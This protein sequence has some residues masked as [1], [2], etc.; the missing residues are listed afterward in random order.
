MTEK[1][2]KHELHSHI[3][4][5]SGMYIGSVEKEQT[6]TYI[7]KE[8]SEIFEKKNIQYVPGFYKIVD[9]ILVN[10]SDQAT[11][12]LNGKETDIKQ[13]KNIKININKETGE[14]SVYNDGD[15]I[16]I[17]EHTEYN[18][19]YI[20]SLIFGELLTSTNY[21][22]EEEKI[23]GGINGLGAK[24]T[25][26]FST[27]FTIETVDFRRSKL[28]KQTFTE[29]MYKK[30]K[31]SI[32]SSNKQPYTKITFL[33]DYKRFGLTE[34]SEDMFELFHKRC[35]DLCAVTNGNVSVFFNDVKINIK[36]FEKYCDMYL[37]LKTIQPRVYEK[38][39]E[40]WEIIAS[41]SEIG[42]QQVSFVNG[43]CVFNG[44]TNIQYITNQITK[45][46][47]D[48][49]AKKKKIIKPN[50]IKEHL[51]IFVK[52]SIINPSFNSQSKE[53]LTTPVSKFGSKC[54]ISDSFMTKLYKTGIIEKASALTEFH[55]IKKLVKTDGKKSTRVIIEKLDDAIKAGTK[56]SHLCTLILTEGDSARTTAVS[57]LSVVGREYYGVFPLK[58]KVMNVKDVSMAKLNENTEITNLKKIIGLEH[59]KKYKDIT[60]LR[61]GKIMIMCDADEDGK[62]IQALLFNLFHSQ[63]HDLFE[64]DNFL[65][66]L[67]TPIIKV[68]NSNGTIISFYTE[69]DY[70]NWEKTDDSKK[71]GW[72][73]KY[74]K[75]LGTSSDS[76]AKEYFRNMKKITYK[77]NE[78]S[79]TAMEL[80][81]NKK[82][83]DER[84]EWLMKYDRSII[85]NIEEKEVF[86]DDFINKSLIHF[87]NR[88]LERSIPSIC[89]G[90]KESMRKILFACFKKKLTKEIK[91]AQLAGYVSEH[92]VYK[93]GENSLQG[94]IIGLAQN[95]IGTNNLN[96]LEP[97]GQ[98]GCLSGETEILM[99]DSSLKIAENI[100]IGDQ[101]IG[102]NGEKRVVKKLTTGIDNMYSINIENGKSFIGNSQHMLTLLYTDHKKVHYNIITNSVSI[103]FYNNYT[104]L[105][106]TE[107][108]YLDLIINTVDKGFKQLFENFKHINDNNIFDIKI[109]DFIKIPFIYKQNFYCIQNYN[110]INWNINLSISINPYI[111]GF[112]I[113]NKSLYNLDI[114]DKNVLD[115]FI[116][117]L[118]IINCKLEAYGPEQKEVSKFS[119]HII[120]KYSK[121]SH[122]WE[123]L[124]K[125]NDL[126]MKN[127]PNNYIFTDKKNRLELL[128]G[129]IDSSGYIIYEN[130][131]PI[132]VIQNSKEYHKSLQILIQSLGFITTIDK[133]EILYIYGNNLY[134][135]PCKIYTNIIYNYNPRYNIYN[136]S[137]TITP[138]GNY[139]FYGWE[140]DQNNRFLLGN[141]IITH[142]SRIQGG[143]DA[144]SPRYIYTLLTKLCKIVYNEEDSP[145]LEYKIDEGFSIEPLYY[146]PIIPM[147]LVNGTQ[148]IGTG[149]ST[150][151]PNY[152]PLDIINECKLVC[153]EIK[154][155]NIENAD[156]LL[157]I[158]NIINKIKFGKLYPWYLGNKG[159]IIKK[160]NENSYISKGVYNIVDDLHIEITELP[161]YFWTED[162]KEF[163]E[164]M[165]IKN[166]IK[167]FESHYTT[168]NVKF[169]IKLNIGY[170]KSKIETDFK[171]ISSKNLSCNNFHL[172]SENGTIT[173]YNTTSDILREWISV[174]IT[175]YLDRKLYKI[176]IL[177]KE[178]K[179]ISAK[180]R[181]ITDVISYKIKI[182][183]IPITDIIDILITLK[184]PKLMDDIDIEEDNKNTSYNYLLKL[185]ISQ[186]TKER[187]EKLEKEAEKKKIE[188]E[189][190][191]KKPIYK[192]WEDEL[193]LLEMEYTKFMD[194]IN[195]DYKDDLNNTPKTKSSLK[196]KK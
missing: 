60:S 55:D 98:F 34:L 11:R 129:I 191:R 49:A 15:G 42:F 158:F 97:N 170:D 85:L 14:I 146:I 166:K 108:L 192:M 33:P 27:K 151:I 115:Y 48:M 70:H 95:F 178:F 102:D 100:Q 41:I 78:Y 72:T 35:Y 43:I 3:L 172:Y 185:P 39:N 176:K 40:R 96:I 69:T 175:K 169:L 81:F 54:D 91:V 119:F 86:Y 77:Y 132:I 109:C 165:L 64:M 20:P 92:T 61:Y 26:I 23:I 160:E 10:A 193:L 65:T 163:L 58:G 7:Y 80:A 50:H 22:K 2:K 140:I 66:S 145:I 51:S 161:V 117:Y 181:F 110:C 113:A 44:G 173:K 177:E 53:N 31:P 182:M 8:G 144:S 194:E 126:F 135:I 57:G 83:A 105:I 17:I 150:T 93:H 184:Y 30:G 124:L 168:K 164:D 127:I 67:M 112:I 180:C 159:E 63:W 143:S 111:T 183:N 59:N 174:R 13:V 4:E 47:V 103:I 137:F 82:K 38:A 138:F 99:W 1:Y 123:N 107:Y 162:Y 188:I 130:E 121:F 152:N 187:K 74:F 186:L 131:N 154:E 18:N 52:C 68:T 136:K 128:A 29:N 139:R 116:E 134:E 88:D 71:S 125:R 46:L 189:L 62:H 179:Y 19:I 37:G 56:E 28:F 12:L 149:F 24:L 73:I 167:D 133:Y 76:E 104:Q 195:K 114:F 141:F 36:D 122:I 94:A 106:E 142:N 148:G 120:D 25:N 196:K 87:S 84:K 89:D 190:L 79:D 147:I 171:L 21:N 6:E 157:E 156:N 75:G 90:L 45:N 16:D 101:L 155:I 32:T 9:E 153:N 118:N 5:I